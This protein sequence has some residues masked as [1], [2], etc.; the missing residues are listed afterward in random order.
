[1]ALDGGGVYLDVG[2]GAVSA[3]KVVEHAGDLSDVGV[4]HLIVSLDHVED[5]TGLE[6]IGR[7]VIPHLA[8]L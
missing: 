6:L 7:D 8:A 1:V 2:G 3:A 4:Q 5:I